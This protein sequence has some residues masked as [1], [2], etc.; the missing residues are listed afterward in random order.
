LQLSH[1]AALAWADDAHHEPCCDA[2]KAVCDEQGIKQCPPADFR[3]TCADFC[4]TPVEAPRDCTNRGSKND[5]IF[6]PSGSANGDTIGEREDD[7]YA[8][9]YIL[10]NPVP[11]FG[12]TYNNVCFSSNGVISFNRGVTSYTSYTFPIDGITMLSPFWGDFN[13]ALE[14]TWS[15]RELR[16]GQDLLTAS[17]IVNRELDDYSD[18]VGTD[19]VVVT[20]S[21]VAFYGRRNSDRT[22]DMQAILIH[23]NNHSFAI[24]QYGDIEW[25]SGTASGNSDSCDGLGGTP[26]QV[27]FNDGSGKFYS[28]PGSQTDEMQNIEDMTNCK[29]TGRLIFKVDSNPIVGAAPRIP[30][31][32]VSIID[33]ISGIHTILQDNGHDLSGHGCQCGRMGAG[34]ASG[35]GRPIDALDKICKNWISKRNCI[36]KTGGECHPASSEN[37]EADPSPCASKNNACEVLACN[38]DQVFLDEVEQFMDANPGWTPNS[39]ATCERLN[40]AP[41][42]VAPPKKD[43]CC[44]SSAATIT[45]YAS[46]RY[47]CV[48]DE[49]L[50]R[51]QIPSAADCTADEAWDEA[52]QSCSATLSEILNGD[53]EWEQ[54]SLGFYV[55]VSDYGMG[56]D[57]AKAYCKNLGQGSEMAMPANAEQNQVFLDSLRAHTEAWGWWGFKRVRQGQ[58]R[59]PWLGADLRDL[60]W[61]D[62]CLEPFGSAWTC[63]IWNDI[64]RD[65]SNLCWSNVP[66]YLRYRAICVYY[67]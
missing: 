29:T 7:T 35:Q 44:G 65:G 57:D 14:G 45:A 19:G 62:W 48:E 22:N 59:G 36:Q 54:N 24:F 60:N 31:V 61:N 55:H 16:A 25:T 42:Y 39:S 41:G 27:G 26:A 6:M 23:D 30:G 63:A 51:S 12:S 47:V 10:R 53:N 66:C 9:P 18:F 2:Q 20:Y 34:S 49:L 64:E 3:S 37:Y 13:T 32:E 33:P 67:A 56:W 17:G 11:Y 21:K 40:Q 4:A 15:H 5:G 52:S 58:G 46:E 8:G 28:V 1:R 50:D 43:S 38:I